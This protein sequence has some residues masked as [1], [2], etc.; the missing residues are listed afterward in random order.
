MKTYSQKPAEVTRKW[1]ILDA[2]QASLGRVATV[3]A[4]LLIGKGKPTVTAHTDGGDYVVIINADNL[5][6][7]G[8]K[9]EDKIYYNHSGFPGGLR[10]RQLRDVASTEALTTA[11]RGMLPVNKLRDGRLAR[12]KVYGGAEHNHNA[13]TPEVYDLKKGSN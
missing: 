2:S 1:Y 3:A 8:K 11:V 13:Q 12:L 5:V 4:S 6:V 9:I 7:T 10:E